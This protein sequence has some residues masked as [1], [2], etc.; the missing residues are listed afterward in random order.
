M[1]SEPM[2]LDIAKVEELWRT[3]AGNISEAAIHR[4][5]QAVAKELTAERRRSTN[6]GWGLAAAVLLGLHLAL[7]GSWFSA[8]RFEL[9]FQP[10]RNAMDLRTNGDVFGN[11]DVAEF[12]QSMELMEISPPSVKSSK[13]GTEH[14]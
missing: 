6:F 9:A 10:A 4:L 7:A 12:L 13:K 1:T 8:T 3:S 2:D 5:R 14:G 11:Q